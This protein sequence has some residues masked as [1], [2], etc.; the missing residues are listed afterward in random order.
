LR[1]DKDNI[2]KKDQVKKNDSDAAKKEVRTH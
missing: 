1:M 2:S